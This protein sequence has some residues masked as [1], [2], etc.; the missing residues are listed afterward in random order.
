MK[1]P[2]PKSKTWIAEMRDALNHCEKNYTIVRDKES[3]TQVLVNFLVKVDWNTKW[4]WRNFNK[5]IVKVVIC[6]LRRGRRAHSI[7]HQLHK[8]W[9][10][11]L[12]HVMC[13]LIC[14]GIHIDLF[15][16]FIFAMSPFL[17]R[18]RAH[19]LEVGEGDLELESWF[20][21]TMLEF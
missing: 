6:V 17:R 18:E 5:V 4:L 12:H 21:G 16:R 2:T 15:H 20:G 10:Y 13:C 3:K 9:K 7:K 8:F 11:F 1:S 19:R 14:D